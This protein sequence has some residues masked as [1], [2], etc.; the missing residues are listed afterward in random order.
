MLGKNYLVTY[1]KKYLLGVITFKSSKI[2]DNL[3][4]K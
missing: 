1:H 4:E 2:K 3:A